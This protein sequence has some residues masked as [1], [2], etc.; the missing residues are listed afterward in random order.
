VRLPVYLLVPFVLV[1]AVV[2]GRARAAVGR[3]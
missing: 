1:A 3:A 2:G